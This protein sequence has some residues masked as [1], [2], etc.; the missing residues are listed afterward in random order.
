MFPHFGRC[1]PLPS[2]PAG[3]PSH[4]GSPTLSPR[5][6]RLRL[7]VFILPWTLVLKP[8]GLASSS[9]I[10]APVFSPFVSLVCSFARPF[11]DKPSRRGIALS[12]GLRLLRSTFLLFFAFAFNL[13]RQTDNKPSRRAVAHPSDLACRCFLSLHPSNPWR[14]PSFHF[15]EKT[16]RHCLAIH[17]HPHTSSLSLSLLKLSTRGLDLSG[18]RTHISSFSLFFRTHF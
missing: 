11:A 4:F 6:S 5:S 1:I 18:S 8:S 16:M 2:L 10:C 14:S 12:S 7:V 17:P 3:P 9:G 13:S 15:H